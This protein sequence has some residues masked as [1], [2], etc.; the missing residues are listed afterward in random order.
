MPAVGNP[1]LTDA[2]RKALPAGARLVVLFEFF[3]RYAFYSTL[4]LLVLFLSATAADGGLGWSETRALGF[5]GIFFGLMYA[6]PLLGGLIADRLIGHRAAIVVGG[7]MMMLGYGLLSWVAVR[8]G[9]GASDPTD[10]TMLAFWGSMACIVTGNAL[11]KST[12]VIVFGDAFKGDEPHRERSYT[13]YYMGIN[14]G[15]VVAGLASGALVTRLGWPPAFGAA[16]IGMAIAA[17]TF[18][19]LHRRLLGP[20]AATVIRGKPSTTGADDRAGTGTRLGLLAV[21]AAAL[22]LFH[23]GAL[24]IFGS[25]L[26]MIEHGVDR[27]VGEFVIPVQWYTSFNAAALIVA[28][29]GFVWLWARLAR[30]GMEPDA[31]AKYAVALGFGA[32]GLAMLAWTGWAGESGSWIVPALGVVLLGMGEV[33][34]WTMTYGLVYRLAPRRLVAMVMGA[35]YTVTL[36]LGGYGAGWVAGYAEPMGYGRYFMILSI[37]T[38]VA[39]CAMLALRGTINRTAGG[40]GQTL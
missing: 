1:L 2:E 4:S 9:A 15:A 6:L 27:S 8:Q 14:V 39:A 28:P 7:N 23:V 12:A 36:G 33:A 29:A 16:A 19:M 34:A 31:P 18:T 5:V 40:A 10:A 24:Q 22:C 30:R 21:F 17:L 32:A 11:M 38:A 37:V 3:E 25:V 20:A 26:L 13:Y 35:F